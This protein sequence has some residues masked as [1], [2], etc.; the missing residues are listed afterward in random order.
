[1]RSGA[2]QDFIRAVVD[3]TLTTANEVLGAMLDQVGRRQSGN[4]EKIN[5]SWL[6]GSDAGPSSSFS[7]RPWVKSAGAGVRFNVLSI[8]VF[9]TSAVYAFD[10]PQEKWQFLFALQ[11]G[12]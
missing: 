3:P 10:R 2:L 6:G 7:D 4:V 1:V 8:A 9:E 12:F 11:H 5:A